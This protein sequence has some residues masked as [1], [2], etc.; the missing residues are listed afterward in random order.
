M[1]V[2]SIEQNFVQDY[3]HGRI[4]NQII[5]FPKL[6]PIPGFEKGRYISLYNS[7]PINLEFF[8][9]K[10]YIFLLL[11]S[12]GSGH[13]CAHMWFYDSLIVSLQKYGSVA[14]V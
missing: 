10:K 4:L 3:L 6:Q 13:D 11:S 7:I 8:E 9:V 5:F 14:V 2:N 1:Q 12:Q